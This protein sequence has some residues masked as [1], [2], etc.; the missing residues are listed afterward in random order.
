MVAPLNALPVGRVGVI[1]TTAHVRPSQCASL[2]PA[3]QTSCGPR[4]VS[5]STWTGGGTA[6]QWSPSHWYACRPQPI[7]TSLGP[8][9]ATPCAK[10]GTGWPCVGSVAVGAGS[11]GP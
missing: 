9:A 3:A 2:P 10:P 5:D 8:I 1:G 7:Q 6:V 11:F 4:A